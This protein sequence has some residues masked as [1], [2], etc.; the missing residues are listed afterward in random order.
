M[1]L[2]IQLALAA[3]IL[4]STSAPPAAQPAPPSAEEAEATELAD[5]LAMV[6]GL[7]EACAVPD[8]IACESARLALVS[9]LSVALVELGNSGAHD[10][11]AP[12][13]RP[14]AEA[15]HPRL[16]W[17]TATALGAIHPTAEDTETLLALLNDEVP[18]VREAARAALKASEDPGAV[19]IGN[20]AL[21]ADDEAWSPEPVP[22]SRAPLPDGAAFLRFASDA[23]IGAAVYSSVL[24]HADLVAWFQR[25]TGREALAPEAFRDA[26]PVAFGT[27]ETQSPMQRLMEL[28]QRMSTMT[29]AEQ[30]AAMGEMAALQEQLRNITPE[31]MMA[32]MT[33]AEDLPATAALA[34]WLEADRF[35]DPMIVALSESQDGASPTRIAVIYTD[36]LLRR[37]GFALQNVP[38]APTGDQP[39]AAQPRGALAGAD[40]LDEMFWTTVGG[41]AMS[42]RVYLRL[43]PEGRHVAG[44]EALV[45]ALPSEAASPVTE[46][47]PP[48]TVVSPA[49]PPFQPQP[50]TRT[51]RR[52]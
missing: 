16:R 40:L 39:P 48:V 38:A 42:A 18:A 51:I 4:A 35:A 12:R 32:A 44:A 52:R 45:A 5:I 10:A 24:S 30:M 9:P 25:E 49:G 14:F 43:F 13:I 41:S 37:P 22:D 8:S 46:V 11:D 7:D 20:A 28:G 36:R 26:Y 15:D 1:R 50:E 17:A 33:P 23:E 21:A 29:L 27:G 31:Q 19:A 34:P 6:E 3:L 47:P 2:A